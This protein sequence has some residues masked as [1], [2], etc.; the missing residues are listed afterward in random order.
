MDATESKTRFRVPLRDKA[1][2]LR[3]LSALLQAGLPVSRALTV[4]AEQVGARPLGQELNQIL[5]ELQ[6]GYALSRAFRQWDA[7]VVNLIEAGESGGML[8]DCFE[9]LARFYEA[10][11][12][13]QQK[14]MTSLTYPL[15]IL[16]VALVMFLVM[17]TTILPQFSEI[18]LRLGASLPAY[19][20]FWIQMS[21]W[22]QSPLIMGGLLG[23]LLLLFL[24]RDQLK[25]Y[26]PDLEKALVYLPVVGDLLVQLSAARFARS[27]G[28]L[29][30]SGV[31]ISRALVLTHVRLLP[32]DILAEKISDGEAL[33]QAMGGFP[34]LF[35][36]LLTAMVA[37]GEETGDLSPLLL[38]T[39]DIYDMELEGTLNRLTSFLEPV[40][41]LVIGTLIGSVVVGM[42]LPMFQ[43]FELIS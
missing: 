15:I 1:T 4:T 37:V 19:T 33:N 30:R 21:Q 23:A 17:I 26:W 7:L 42:Y 10:Q 41:I 27:L 28:T 34:R 3:Q 8:S 14:L 12:R 43:L 20:R 9:R 31:P 13:L 35:P 39:A 5:A 40:I 25:S 18:Y 32:L 11:Y 2:V 36:S 6:E 16:V 38:K 22:L 24:S 29:L